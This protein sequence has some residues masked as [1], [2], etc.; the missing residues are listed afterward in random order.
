[1]LADTIVGMI[2]ASMTLQAG[3]AVDPQRFRVDHRFGPPPHRAGAHRVE[4]R[5]DALP[6]KGVQRAVALAFGAGIDLG[7]E[8]RFERALRHDL[9]ASRMP[10]RNTSMLLS[11]RKKL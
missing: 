5:A 3:D 6:D 4:E 1:M 2:E 7:V 10:A 8:M 9:R 11:P